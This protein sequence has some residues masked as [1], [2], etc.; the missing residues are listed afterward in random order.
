MRRSRDRRNSLRLWWQRSTPLHHNPWTTAPLCSV[1]YVALPI[2]STTAGNSNSC[3]SPANARR[4]LQVTRRTTDE[5]AFGENNH[6]KRSHEAS[7]SSHPSSGREAAGLEDL[8]LGC[9]RTDSTW[10]FHH[11]PPA[12]GRATSEPTPRAPKSE[13]QEKANGTHNH[14]DYT[15]CVQTESCR[16]TVTANRRIAPIARTTRLVPTPIWALLSQEPP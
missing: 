8:L 12:P 14:E 3:S 2:H 1:A 13:R 11:G 5:A 15:D 16:V 10:S 6:R 9:R 7:H 4:Y